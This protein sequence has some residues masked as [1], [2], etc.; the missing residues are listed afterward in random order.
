[1][2]SLWL[3]YGLVGKVNQFF[4]NPRY[5]KGDRQ[6]CDVIVLSGTSV[7]LIECKGSTVSADGKYGGDPSLLDAELKKKFVG[8]ETSRKGVRQLVEA[9]QN[10]FK[11]DAQDQV[12]GIDLGTIENVIP[13]LLTR[14]DIGSA[15]NFS[16]YLNFHFQDLIRGAT[17]THTVSPLCALSAD[18]FEKLAPYLVDVSLSEIL[19]ARLNADKDLIFPLWLADN[20]IL[21]NLEPRPSPTLTGEIEKLGEICRIGLGLP[22][23]EPVGDL[24]GPSS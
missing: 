15:F 22:E 12:S 5:L 17:F 18:D 6:V 20:A 10:L 14:D 11:K 9:I 1:M 19:M 3:S 4:P 21:D 13:V 23:D 16:A 7:V 24:A 8:T 2:F